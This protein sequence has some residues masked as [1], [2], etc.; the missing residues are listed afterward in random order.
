MPLWGGGIKSPS[1][2]VNHW[3][4]WN[5][6]VS[7]FDAATLVDKDYHGG[8]DG[9]EPLT[10]TIIKNCGDSTISSDDV[11][12]CYNDIIQLHCKTIGT[13]QCALLVERIVE[14]VLPPFKK[15]DG[16]TA[17]ELVYFYD[18]FQKT[19]SVY[20]LPFMPFDAI[21]IKLSF[22]GLCPPGIGIYRYA[23]VAT[24]LMDVLPRDMPERISCLGT[25]IAVV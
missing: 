22:E 1:N 11:I 12:L 6:R 18:E 17:A 24:A 19:A 16:I 15:L 7:C 4:A 25:I 14:K 20:L 13:L 5:L 10:I 8:V 3:S 2:N 9:F 23:D 21:S